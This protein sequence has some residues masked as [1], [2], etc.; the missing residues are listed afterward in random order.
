ML[1]YATG[2]RRDGKSWGH[3]L[4]MPV[5]TT[6]PFVDIAW[7]SISSNHGTMA[8]N[9]HL[10]TWFSKWWTKVNTKRTQK[11]EINRKG[12]LSCMWMTSVLVFY[13]MEILSHFLFHY[14]SEKCALRLN[15][16][17]SPSHS[18]YI[19]AKEEPEVLLS[20]GEDTVRWLS[21]DSKNSHKTNFRLS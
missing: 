15:C 9:S 4:D 19:P 8:P 5:Y 14:L 13:R 17:P 10:G 16:I 3:H 21:S 1:K 7:A 12:W 11:G 20:K 6:A 2:R 18:P